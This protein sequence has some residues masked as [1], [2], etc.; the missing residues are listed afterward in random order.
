MS[1]HVP[2]VQAALLEARKW[3]RAMK[4]GPWC[5]NSRYIAGASR[6]GA[7]P[8]GL[9][10]GR[11]WLSAGA[12]TDGCPRSALSP[13]EGAVTVDGCAGAATVGNG[14]CG[15]SATWSSA[16]RRRAKVQRQTQLIHVCWCAACVADTT[17][18]AAIF[19]ARRAVRQS[20]QCQVCCGR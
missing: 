11:S 4:L 15:R 1:A 13:R 9:H 17:V 19:Q 2:H 8:G 6:S 7:R 18:T 12:N 3:E 5:S 20:M 14:A 16:A 10:T